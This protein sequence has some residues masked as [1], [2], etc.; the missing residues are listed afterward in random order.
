M[1]QQRGK[2]LLHFPEFA[3]GAAPEAWRIKDESI[4]GAAAADFAR[5]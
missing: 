1:T 5:R 4:I 3:F 2:R